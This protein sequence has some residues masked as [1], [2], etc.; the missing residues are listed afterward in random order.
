MVRDN[1]AE[2]RIG[3]PMTTEQAAALRACYRCQQSLWQEAGWMFRQQKR[4]FAVVTLGVALSR[5]ATATAQQPAPPPIPAQSPAMNRATG[6][7]SDEDAQRQFRSLEDIRVELRS[8]GKE[9]PTDCS[10]SVFQGTR[11]GIALSPSITEFHWAPANFSHQPLYFD[12]TPLERYG[13]SVAPH[14]QPIIS[15]GR[16]FLTLPIMPYKLGVDHPYDCVTILGHY[17][18]GV[19]APCVMQV[20]PPLQCSAALLEAGTAVGIALL[21]P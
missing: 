3:W 14:L 6:C 17:R 16:F 7:P 5:L 15:G 21:I 19:C 20:P 10:Q 1:P 13:Q 4:M 2:T 8:E 12:D 18:P 11:P 9:V